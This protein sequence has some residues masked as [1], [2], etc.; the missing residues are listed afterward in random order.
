A[1]TQT[2]LHEQLE[3]RYGNAL[4]TI[5]DDLPS[6]YVIKAH[7]VISVVEMVRRLVSEDERRAKMRGEAISRKQAVL[8][9]LPSVNKT[10][11]CMEIKGASQEIELHAGLTTYYKYERL[12]ETYHGDE[13]QI[14]TSFR[15]ATFRLPRMSPAQ[16]H[17][18]DLCLLLY[19][20][21]TRS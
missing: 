4:G 7:V 8:R 12:Y 2:A 10:S 9:A 18:I 15:R 1:P 20:G 16:F 6:S 17:F 3:E 21:N 13:A 11:I 19:Y 14:A 5:T